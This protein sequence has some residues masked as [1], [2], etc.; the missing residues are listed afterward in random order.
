MK[1]SS[2]PVW[3]RRRARL[4]MEQLLTNAAVTNAAPAGISA[5]AQLLINTM[6]SPNISPLFAVAG[7]CQRGAKAT[8]PS[9][10]SFPDTPPL[11]AA[12]EEA[13][14]S[15]RRPLNRPREGVAASAEALKPAGSSTLSVAPGAW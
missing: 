15:S 8:F 3:P 9:F 6:R 5:G 1:R 13:R 10:P 11:D 4:R 7:G 2:V 12:V 14:F